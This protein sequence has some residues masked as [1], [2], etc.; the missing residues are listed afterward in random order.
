M[1]ES[2]MEEEGKNREGNGWGIEIKRFFPFFSLE[3]LFYV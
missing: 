3:L 1:D 2:D